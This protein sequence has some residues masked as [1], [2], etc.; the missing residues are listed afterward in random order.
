MKTIKRFHRTAY[1]WIFLEIHH[2]GGGKDAT[3]HYDG[4]RANG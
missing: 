2:S 4:K 3:A 1:S